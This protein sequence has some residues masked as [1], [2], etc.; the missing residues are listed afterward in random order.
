MST[1]TELER[2]HQFATE[3]LDLSDFEPSLDELYQMWRTSHLAADELAESVQAVQS[4]L[5]DMAA[6]DSGIPADD[7]LAELRCRYGIPVTR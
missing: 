6:G 5:A 1:R 2:F 7:H 3:Q 4:A